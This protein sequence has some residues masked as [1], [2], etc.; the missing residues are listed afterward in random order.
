MGTAAR[1]SRHQARDH[2]AHWARTHTGTLTYAALGDS[3]GVGVGVDDPNRG[4]V[5]II[6]QRLA[7]TTGQSVRTVNLAVSGAR[8]QDLLETQIPELSTM[9]PADFVTCVIGGND[10]SWAP[11]FRA[12]H[13]ARSMQAIAR[14]LPQDAVMGL[15]PRFAHWPYEARARRA[16][17]AIRAAAETS[18]QAVA[19]I[20]AG[21]KKLSLAGYMRTFAPDY[22]H[23]NETGHQLW[24]DA[25]WKQL[26]PHDSAVE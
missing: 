17:R 20:H 12:R 2:A 15:V 14:R 9:A 24:A 18:G 16:N 5:G 3:A 13:F 7:E 11:F 22:F 4:Y 21:T 6:A 23:P 10:V 1:K 25:I 8:A 26:I 19:D